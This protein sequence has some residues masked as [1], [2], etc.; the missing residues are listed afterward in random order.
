MTNLNLFYQNDKKKE[1]PPQNAY[2][3]PGEFCSEQTF[4]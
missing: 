1:N 4:N 3:Q 2:G